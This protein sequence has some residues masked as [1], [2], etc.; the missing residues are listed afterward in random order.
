MTV[1]Y[2]VILSKLAQA[3]FDRLIHADRR[4]GAQIAKAIDRLARNPNL[5]E[6]LKGE[7]KG[8]RKYRTGHYRIVYRIEHE[9]LLIYIITIGDRKDVYQ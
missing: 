7:W 3:K 2:A 4:L 9:R 1:R 5:G 6:F 8:Y